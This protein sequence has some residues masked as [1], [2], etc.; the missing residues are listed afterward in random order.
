MLVNSYHVDFP[1]FSLYKYA[2]I[3]T[4][5]PDLE[6]ASIYGS[7]RAFS[8]AKG[9]TVEALINIDPET[10]TFNWLCT[11]VETGSSCFDR[12]YRFINFADSPNMTVEP[13]TLWH[14]Q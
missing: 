13:D 14:G 4:K 1:T 11:D 7:N 12:D 10:C 2:F 5:A 3:N 8:V 9:F 6:V